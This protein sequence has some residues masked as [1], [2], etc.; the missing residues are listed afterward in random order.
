M[1]KL[2]APMQTMALPM[3]QATF[4]YPQ[5]TLPLY[6]PMLPYASQP[7]Q[8]PEPLQTEGIQFDRF[9]QQQ[10][11]PALV[12]TQQDRLNAQAMHPQQYQQFKAMNI[13]EG[14]IQAI[15]MVQQI[16]RAL[17]PAVQRQFQALLDKRVIT[18]G[19]SDD[20]HSGLYHLY[21]ILTTP[22]A[23]GFDNRTILKETVQVLSQPYG[24]SQRFAPVSPEAAQKLMDARNNPG[25]AGRFTPPSLN[26]LSFEDLNVE[27]SATCVASSVMY[28]MA[29]KE[30]T[31]FARHINELTSPMNAFFEKAKFE[32]I[33]PDNPA[34]A[35][36]ILRENQIPYYV[37]GPGEVTVKVENP[38]AGVIRAVASQNLP[39][40]APFRNAI[41]AAYQSAITYLVTHSYD[42][43]SDLRDSDIP[44]E[45]SK[46]LTEAEKT[47][48]EAIIKDNGGVQSV[49]YQAVNNK[50]NPAPGE[51][52]NSYLFGYN[53][54]FEQTTQDIL[55]ALRLNEPVI[56]GTTDTD[57]TGAIIAG[58]EI[59]ITGAF[60]DP[61]DN[62]LKFVVADSDDNIAA[63]V[64]KSA[65]ELIP[66]I[67]HAGLPLSIARRIN[68][69]IQGNQGY[70]IPDQQ[71]QT[72]FKLLAREVGPMPMESQQAQSPEMPYNALPSPT[73]PMLA[74]PVS[75]WQP[76]PQGYLTPPMAKPAMLAS[77]PFS[78]IRM[79]QPLLMAAP[80]A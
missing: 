40:G 48:M 58:H 41:G 33:S 61:Q 56:I 77:N 16:M 72:N 11:K 28:Y 19:K 22:R 43:A 67:H 50:A 39:S 18:Q 71:D 74:S 26:P 20:G 12:E 8:P 59:T 15:K 46:G 45:T 35:L 64:V 17:D 73:F 2:S 62:Q 78:Q 13:P 32:E 27:S 42:P 25:L 5:T 80:A 14:P 49:T 55:A 76:T 1:A 60:I 52:N 31:G 38:P 79:N 70:L 65:R 9:R 34:Q 23:Q 63:P 24:I 53:R 44:G 7:M 51:E 6:A 36:K 68:Q 3:P 66:T 29:D 37:S 21:G 75:G 69:E 57:E 10:C 30:P 47:L 4:A 54:P